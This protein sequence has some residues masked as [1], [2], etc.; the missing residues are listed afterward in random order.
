MAEKF[1]INE[2]IREAQNFFVKGN[3]AEAEGICA[4][5]ITADPDNAEACHLLGVIADKKGGPER[6][7]QL[8][9]KAIK[10]SPDKAIYYNSLGNAYLGLARHDDAVASFQRAIRLNSSFA[11]AHNNLGNVLLDTGRPAEAIISFKKAIHYRPDLATAYCGLGKG[12]KEL[13]FTGPA[14][15]AF[16]RA[17]YFRDNYPQAHYQLGLS[18]MDEGRLKEAAEHFKRALYFSPDF[19]GTQGSGRVRGHIGIAR[20]SSKD[21]HPTLF[22]VP[23]GTAPDIGFR[24]LRNIYGSLGSGVYPLPLHYIKYC[25]RAELPAQYVGAT[26]SCYRPGCPCVRQMKQGGCVKPYIPLS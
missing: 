19:Y 8:I 23:Y 17:V 20:A 12:L 11:E 14:I 10:Q 21:N 1:S 15:E 6:A 13:G 16:M 24:N 5:I 7:I 25:V 9:T 22:Q 26:N 4:E 18:L 3:L 2:A